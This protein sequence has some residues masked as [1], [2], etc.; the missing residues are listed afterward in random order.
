MSPQQREE[1]PYTPGQG[2]I[3]TGAPQEQAPA[4]VEPH[5]EQGPRGER[6]GLTEGRIVHFVLP[7][8]HHRPAVVVRNWHEASGSCNLQVFLD[9]TNDLDAINNLTREEAE[10]GIIWR[11]SMGYSEEPKPYTWHWP[12]KA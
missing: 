6:P 1:A 10:R 8:G 3:M 7:N 2:T 9:G 4:D 11:T 12:E 5:T